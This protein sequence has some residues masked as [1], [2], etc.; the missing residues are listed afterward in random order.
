MEKLIH[1][2]NKIH[3]KNLGVEEDIIKSKCKILLFFKGLVSNLEV[4]NEYMNI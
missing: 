4:I 2:K 3:V 1:I